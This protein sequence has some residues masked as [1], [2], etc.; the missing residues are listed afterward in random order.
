MTIINIGIS[1]WVA[2]W[3]WE[4]RVLVVVDDLRS[5]SLLEGEIKRDT[6]WNSVEEVLEFHE[7]VILKS[8]RGM[9]G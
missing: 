3:C 9:L 7:I 1:T 6:S 2:I 4:M 5:D 8:S